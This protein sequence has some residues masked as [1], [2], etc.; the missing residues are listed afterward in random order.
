LEVSSCIKTSTHP[1]ALVDR[2]DL[3]I[4]RML[5]GDSRTPFTEIAEKLE[6]SES[7][8]ARALYDYLD[9]HYCAEHVSYR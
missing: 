2:L 8:S 7:T 1:R 3:K 5:Q 6:L 9:C 4:L